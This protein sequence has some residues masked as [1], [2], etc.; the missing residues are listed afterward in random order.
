MYVCVQVFAIVEFVEEKCAEHV[1]HAREPLLIN[2]RRLTV[3]PRDIKVRGKSDEHRHGDDSEPGD[4]DHHTSNR[5]GRKFKGNPNKISGG[6]FEEQ[7]FKFDPEVQRQL[8]SVN[9]VS[10]MCTCV[11]VALTITIPCCRRRS[12]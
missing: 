7:Q 12:S 3:K 4:Q 8:A 10:T 9:S 11:N 2:G 1:L 6:Y 5:R